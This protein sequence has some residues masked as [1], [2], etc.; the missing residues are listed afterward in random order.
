M[1][2]WTLILFA[3]VGILASTDSNA[4]TNVSGFATETECVA[5]GKR[6]K[7]LV[8]GTKI[9]IAFVCVKQT[10]HAK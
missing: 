1:L 9:E 6:S 10:S 3:H 8:S 4:L 5:A 2:T 7:D